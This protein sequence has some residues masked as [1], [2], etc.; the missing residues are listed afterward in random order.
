MDT[1]VCPHWHAHMQLHTD[2][3]SLIKTRAHTSS[4]AHT[5][6][7]SAH[8][9]IAVPSCPGVGVFLEEVFFQA[10]PRG[11][12][13]TLWCLVG[14][15]VDTKDSPCSGPGLPE[16]LPMPTAGLG[17]AG[18]FQTQTHQLCGQ[19]GPPL[20]SAGWTPR[21]HRPIPVPSETHRHLTTSLCP[22]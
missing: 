15:G 7:R 6:L 3:L 22:P 20:A 5:E 16:C 13:I 8:L 21:G 12:S 19:T 10:P 4:N 14:C 17:S 2:T 18:W 11:G 9:P 1:G